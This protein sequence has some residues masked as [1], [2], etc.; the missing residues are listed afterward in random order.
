[1]LDALNLFLTFSVI[2]IGAT[3]PV[4]A[5]CSSFSFDDQ[6]SCCC[7]GPGQEIQDSCCSSEEPET[8]NPFMPG[9]KACGCS[10]S[11]YDGNSPPAFVLPKRNKSHEQRFLLNVSSV[12]PSLLSAAE[13]TEKRHSF[14]P[15]SEAHRRAV[16]SYLLNCAY[17]I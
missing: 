8:N 7:Q 10:I 11:D 5:H 16:P 9:H 14:S 17:L 1:M 13:L 3:P 6:P 12:S 2:C 15:S 4:V